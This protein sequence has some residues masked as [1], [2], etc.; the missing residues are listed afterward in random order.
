MKLECFLSIVFAFTIFS[1]QLFAQDNIYKDVVYLKTGIVLE[2]IIFEQ[3][4]NQSIKIETNDHIIHFIKIDE[5][6]KI[7]K[8]KVVSETSKVRYTNLTQLSVGKK[9]FDEL[10]Q[11]VLFGI[12]T[13]NGIAFNPYVSLGFGIGANDYTNVAL[14]MP[15]FLDL[16]FTFNNQNIAPYLAL[17]FGYSSSFDKYYGGGGMFNLSFGLKIKTAPR[18]AIIAGVGLLLQNYS[19]QQSLHFSTSTYSVDEVQLYGN[20]N[21]GFVF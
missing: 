18:S 15:V 20:F 6:E 12:E 11:G 8:E 2:G 7:T 21:I 1:F 17:D 9:P 14:M 19:E 5:I 3:I 10:S 13:I 16:R 4:P